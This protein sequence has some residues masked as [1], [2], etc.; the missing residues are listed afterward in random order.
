MQEYR[1]ETLD[2]IVTNQRWK[3]SITNAESQEGPNINSD[4]YPVIA[5]I[6]IRFKAIRKMQ[7]TDEFVQFI[8]AEEQQWK[9]YNTE[10]YQKKK[11]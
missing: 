5:T 4:H 9:K 1:Y 6:N 8:P 3:N 7:K 10:L 11:H 2:Y